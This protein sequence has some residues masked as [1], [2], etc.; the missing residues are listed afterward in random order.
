M[1]RLVDRFG[2]DS[3]SVGLFRWLLGLCLVLDG[4]NKLWQANEFFTDW[5]IMP[6]SPWISD[7]MNTWKFSFHLA[8]GELW[9]QVLLIGLGIVL[10]AAFM[11]GYRWRVAGFAAFVLL[12]S[13]QSRNYLILSSAD[14][15][16]RMALFWFLFMK[17]PGDFAVD[18]PRRARGE[19]VNDV[20]VWA[21][22]LQLLFIYFF[23]AIYKIHPVYTQEFSAVYYAL[24]IDYFVKPLGVL[25][26][27]SHGLMQFLTASTLVWEFAGPFLAVLPFWR[28]RLL[29]A[30]GFQIFHFGLF[31]TLALAMFPWISIAY[32][33]LFYPSQVWRT[34]PF[35][36]AEGALEAATGW[37]AARL[38]RPRPVK[39]HAPVGTWR[40]RARVAAGAAFLLLV[41]AFNVDGLEKKSLPHLLPDW[42]EHVVQTA[43]VN[44]RWNMFAPY[45][46]RNDGWFVIEGTFKNGLKLDLWTGRP[47]TK[48]KP[49][50][51]TEMYSSGEWRKFMMNVWDMGSDAILQPFARHLCRRYALMPPPIDSTVNTLTITF[52]KERTPAPG[53]EP[54]PV[55]EVLLWTHSCF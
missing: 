40:G 36:R 34:A 17:D 15:V 53:E 8:S 35:R 52:M 3:R 10:S 25:L 9:F 24:E 43:N 14:D 5:G 20:A 22:A 26:R 50:A 37:L 41:A 33:T 30:L 29:A 32:W 12:A 13:L 48:E 4:F 1:S 18:G 6:R 55:Q 7:F 21:L 27:Q 44:Q 42:S 51:A 46:I 54:E 45:P 23:T 16:I 39:G 28:V 11:I 38:P 49:A 2:F 19:N 47:V 31:T